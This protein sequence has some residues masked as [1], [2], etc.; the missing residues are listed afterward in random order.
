MRRG[1]KALAER[2]A[3]DARRALKLG[4]VA[5]LDPWAYARHLQVRVLSFAEL[6]LT[7]NAVRQLTVTDGGSWSAMT[8]EEDGRCKIVLNPAHLVPRQRNDL[9]HEL[10]HIELGHRAARVEVS[11]TGLMLLSDYSDEQEQEADWHAG[12]L[13]LPR[14]ALVQWRSRG[15]DANTIAEHYG[16]SLQLC[17]WRLRMTGVETQ[18]RRRG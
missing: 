7:P 6:D 10:A 3:L 9:M 15:W 18:M 8:L 1:F 12:A 17:E 14:P 13:L 11:S 2:H 4:A 16:V 5:P